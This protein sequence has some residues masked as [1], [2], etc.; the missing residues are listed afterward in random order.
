[1]QRR[2]DSREVFALFF[3]GLFIIAGCSRKHDYG[4]TG[5]IEGRLTM[6]GKPLPK[7]TK[8]LF[9]E[10]REGFLA[11]GATD[12]DGRFKIASWNDGN[13][14]VG[15]Y[16]VTIQPAGMG[17]GEQPFDIDAPARKRPAKKPAAGFPKRYRTITTS[18]LEYTVD[19]GAND[20]TIDI[21][22][23]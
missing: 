18:K 12:E 8:V 5:T 19:E 4:P 1:M 9:M 22:S 10:Q 17:D 23:K 15:K 20:F 16:K 3:G 7:G 11:F 13:M 6:E 21:K 2:I 14:P